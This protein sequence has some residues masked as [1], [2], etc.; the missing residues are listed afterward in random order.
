MLGIQGEC[1]CG[2]FYHPECLKLWPHAWSSGGSR[3]QSTKKEDQVA[4]TCPQHVCHT[5]ASD[6]PRNTSTRYNHER[7]VRCIRC[8]TAYH[9]ESLKIVIKPVVYVC[10]GGSLICCDL[11]P[12]AFHAECLNISA[13][14][15]GYICEDC[16]TGRFPLYGEI[17]WVK[18]GA[19]R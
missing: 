19:Y 1:H 18:L 14:E 15:G 5:C 12:T 8:P 4:V 6:D 7:L 16:D 17:V 2:R 3:R 13:P 11:C 9:T 10:A